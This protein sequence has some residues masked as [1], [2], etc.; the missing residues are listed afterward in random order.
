MPIDA[1]KDSIVSSGNITIAPDKDGVYRR[2]PFFFS[3]DEYT[4][5]HFLLNYLLDKQ[6][7]SI[8]DSSLF[9]KDKKLPMLDGMLILN[10]YSEGNA[11]K[12]F[13]A[14]HIL[15]SYLDNKC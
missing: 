10:Y 12:S 11:F 8:K 1:Y 4:V 15:K 5:P 2:I 7:V 9:S 3:I 14:S 13:S 6:I